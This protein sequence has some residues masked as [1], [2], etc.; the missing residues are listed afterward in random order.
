M[1]YILLPVHN[2]REVT[3]KFIKCLKKQSFHNFQLIL[4][5]D[6]STDCTDKMVLNELPNTQIIYG[7]GNLW[8]AGALQAGFE[9][10]RN[11]THNKDE[12]VLL[13]NDDVEF[14]AHF[15]QT[16][17]KTMKEEKNKI[18]LKSWCIDKYSKQINDGYIH[19]NL[20]KLTF[21]DTNNPKLANCASTR[22]LFL[23]VTDFINI[24]G[25][26]PNK[27]PHY[28]SDY[29]FTIRA[30]SQLGYRIHCNEKLYLLSDSAKSGYH[31][32]QYNGFKEF[33]NHFFSIKCP[34]NPKYLIQFTNVVCKNKY[35][36]CF[37]VISILLK[38]SLK[39]MLAFAFLFY[40]KE[41]KKINIGN[42]SANFKK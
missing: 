17:M 12:V 27:L 39:L 23:K 37:L 21:K 2:R 36:K 7:N 15:L 42:F 41:R 18:L 33:L 24:G 32:I 40:T 14:D 35:N 19:A 8:W 29:E 13:I 6:G 26:I 11:K 28:L 20:N 16:A 5:D 30:T 34:T 4:I 1:L 10:L 3:K 31:T 25:F 9:Y 38:S 22:G